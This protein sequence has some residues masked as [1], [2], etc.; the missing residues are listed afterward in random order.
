M[1][2]SSLFLYSTNLFF[3]VPSKNKVRGRPAHRHRIFYQD[4][5]GRSPF[6]TTRVLDWFPSLRGLWNH[7]KNGHNGFCKNPPKI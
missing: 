1:K 2:G 6:L 5:T 4:G 7:E 3:C